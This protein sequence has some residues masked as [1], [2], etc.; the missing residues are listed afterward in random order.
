[1]A[2]PK[3][4]KLA[5]CILIRISPDL[6]DA[7][8][9][10][11]DYGEFSKR[12]R[13]LMETYVASRADELETLEKKLEVHETEAQYIRQLIAELREKR[14]GE[15]KEEQDRIAQYEKDLSKLTEF[16]R[17]YDGRVDYVPQMTWKEYS[18]RTG[19]TIDELKKITLER[20]KE[21][22]INGK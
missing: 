17:K 11:C 21:G 13:T 14:A 9:R 8:G 7:F 15:E 3:G 12:M 20:I 10:G 1:M 4:K 2:R 19:K 6:K 16:V 22:G 18:K 5:A